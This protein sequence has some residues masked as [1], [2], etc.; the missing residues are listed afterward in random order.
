M[1][2][3][4]EEI[5]GFLS[6]TKRPLMHML[7]SLDIDGLG[8]ID[9]KEFGEHFQM[10]IDALKAEENRGIRE[11]GAKIVRGYVETLETIECGD[12]YEL[13]FAI[14]FAI[15]TLKRVASGQLVVKG[16]LK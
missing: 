7:K 13:K 4:K 6:E 3:T 12:D 8:E 9:A 14:S 1:E 15:K 2:Y 16:G 5:A 11:R 10:A